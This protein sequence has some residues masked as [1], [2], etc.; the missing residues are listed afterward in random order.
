MKLIESAQ[1]IRVIIRVRTAADIGYCNTAYIFGKGFKVE[2]CALHGT[3]LVPLPRGHVLVFCVHFVVL[4]LWSRVSLLFAED[5]L[6]DPIDRSVRDVAGADWSQRVSIDRR[7]I[8]FAVDS[9][10]EY[11]FVVWVESSLKWNRDLVF[12][13]RQIDIV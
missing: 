11:V 12:A 7:G 3:V 9:V 13:V 8:I 2:D 10:H 5:E 4:S 6:L 1:V